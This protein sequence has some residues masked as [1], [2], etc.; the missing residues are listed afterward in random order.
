M[1]NSSSNFGLPLEEDESS[2][3]KIQ[4]SRGIILRAKRGEK[5]R[6]RGPSR[7]RE[8][9]TVTIART[10]NNKCRFGSPVGLGIPETIFP[11]ARASPSPLPRPGLNTHTAR[12][13]YAV[14]ETGTRDGFLFWM[15]PRVRDAQHPG[16]AA[17]SPDFSVRTTAIPA[18]AQLSSCLAWSIDF[19]DYYFTSTYSHRD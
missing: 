2:F 17:G 4:S 7:C 19:R 18:C 10:I 15:V 16:S 14:P 11:R 3:T 9:S 12:E 5:Q 13:I 1:I 8:T 6:G